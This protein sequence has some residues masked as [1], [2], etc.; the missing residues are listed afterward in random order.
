MENLELN[1]DIDGK[2]PL[3]S[4]IVPTYN[5]EKY[6][7]QCLDGIFMQKVDFPYEVLVH[8]DASPD[9]TADIIREYEAKYPDIIKPIYQTENQY[10][11]DKSI[12][13]RLQYGRAKGKYIAFCEGDDYWDDN[14]KMQFQVDF[15]EEHP[16]YSGTAHNVAVIDAEGEPYNYYFDFSNHPSHEYTLN[17]Y[18]HGKIAGQVGSLIIHNLFSTLDKEILDK[19]YLCKANGDEKIS[20][21]C[22]LNGKVY[23]FDKIMSKYRY[24]TSNSTSWSSQVFSKNMAYDTYSRWMA[25]ANFAKDVYAVSIDMHE[26]WVYALFHA[27]SSYLFNKNQENLDILRLITSACP[28][29]RGYYFYAIKRIPHYFLLVSRKKIKICYRRYVRQHLVK[30]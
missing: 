10:S 4:V 6:I 1:T 8:D 25:T 2:I 15:L 16:E 29:K 23:F 22:L 18:S 11:K 24:V 14:K 13:S 30:N 3:V 21:L 12:I 17:D 28:D 9:G 5:H 7:R 27:I 20:L 19:Y 26:Y